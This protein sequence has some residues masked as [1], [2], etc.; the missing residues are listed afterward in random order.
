[1]WGLYLLVPLMILY[2]LSRRFILEHFDRRRIRTYLQA[3]SVTLQDLN[4]ALFVP[5][6]GDNDRGRTYVLRVRDRD[7]NELEVACRT[8]LFGGVYF[9]DELEG[10]V[11]LNLGH[12]RPKSFLKDAPR[13]Q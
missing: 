3:R 1:M 10:P 12:P 8:S 6:W 5:G 2:I 9:S 7:G 13:S 11:R 4:L